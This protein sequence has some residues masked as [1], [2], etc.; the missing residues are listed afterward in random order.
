VGSLAFIL[1]FA[2]VFVSLGALFGELGSKLVTHQRPLDRL[3]RRHD[4]AGDVLRRV[5]AVEVGCSGTAGCTGCLGSRCS[6]RRA[7]DSLRAG[8]DTLHRSDA[9]RRS[10]ASPSLVGRDGVRGSILAFF[11][12][13]GLGMPFV[14]AALATEWMATASIVAAPPPT[15][16]RSRRWRCSDRHRIAR[17]D[18]RVARLRHVVAD[19][20]AGRRRLRSRCD[21][22]VDWTDETT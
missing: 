9:G 4:S 17:G 22:P 8:M 11:Y 16:D 21:R 18:G 12:C 19:P 2:I 1:G 5:V 10:W 13:L 15:H 7:R 20:R 3:R 6:A 14:V